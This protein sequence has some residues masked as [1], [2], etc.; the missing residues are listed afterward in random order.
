V[1]NLFQLHLQKPL[2]PKYRKIRGSELTL[3]LIRCCVRLSVQPALWDAIAVSCE[4]EIHCE[5]K[6]TRHYNIVHNFAKCET[7]IHS[8]SKK[9]GTTILSITSPNV[10]RFSNFFFH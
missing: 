7:E 2:S 1:C 6:K 8:E 9:Q 4:T 10:D 5:S 3:L